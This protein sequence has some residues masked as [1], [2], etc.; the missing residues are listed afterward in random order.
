MT[1]SDIKFNLASE[2]GWD[3]LFSAAAGLCSLLMR[4]ISKEDEAFGHLEQP[5]PRAQPDRIS[6]L[7]ILHIITSLFALM[8]L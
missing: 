6:V 1:I 8:L 5:P 7:Q 2:S 3:F 4:R